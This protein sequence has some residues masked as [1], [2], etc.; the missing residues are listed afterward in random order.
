[1]TLAP[2]A[3]RALSPPADLPVPPNRSAG[4]PDLAALLA[5]AVAARAGIDGV[6]NRVLR[7]LRHVD[8]ERLRRADLERLP[9]A[10]G[11]QQEQRRPR[12]VFRVHTGSSAAS[13]A[14]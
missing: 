1:A 7:R 11:G 3:P 2:A 8:L 12:D 10:R 6:L 9:G 14:E 13:C 5:L 4:E